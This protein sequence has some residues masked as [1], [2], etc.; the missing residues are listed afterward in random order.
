VALAGFHDDVAAAAA[1]AAR[2]AASRDEL[3]AAEGEAS[4]AAVAG[5]HADIGFVNKHL[6]AVV[7]C[8]LPAKT[9]VSGEARSARQA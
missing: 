3:L 6:K 1:V 5:F 8:Q 9:N 7:S 2:G 4:V